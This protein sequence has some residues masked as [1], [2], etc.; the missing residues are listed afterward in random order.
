MWQIL[1][2]LSTKSVK[3]KREIIFYGKIIR[4]SY[5]YP[6]L[7]VSYSKSN[8]KERSRVW[9]D[10]KKFIEQRTDTDILAK[11]H[12]FKVTAFARKLAYEYTQTP[13]AKRASIMYPEALEM[14]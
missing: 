1:I 12:A 11:T 5:I 6:L 13:Q 4:E 2:L 3:R 8:V 14:I 9:D 7:T 10:M